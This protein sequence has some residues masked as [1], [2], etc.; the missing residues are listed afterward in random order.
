V[1]GVAAGLAWWGP[2]SASVGLSPQA[3]AVIVAVA[4]AGFAVV[5]AR[6]I[7]LVAAA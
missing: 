2:G 6:A 1:V 5:V 7:R 3:A 4:A